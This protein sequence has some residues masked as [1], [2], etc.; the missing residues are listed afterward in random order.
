MIGTTPFPMT[1]K[2][3][4]TL[5]LEVEGGTIV[6]SYWSRDGRWLSGYVVNPSGEANGFGVYDVNVGRARQLNT[7]SRGFDVA[8]L[9]GTRHVVYFTNRGTLVM[10]DVESL[11]RREITGALPYPPDL[12][13]SITAS[14]DGKTLYYGARQ[15][16]SNIW[17]VKRPVAN[18]T[19]P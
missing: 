6:P 1:E 2:T 12:L 8:W 9:P 15:I 10:Q 4:T 19:R 13:K 7:D 14:P 5:P 16:E 17:L 3:A 18:T 11:A